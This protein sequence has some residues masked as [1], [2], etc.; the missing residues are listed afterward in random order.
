MERTSHTA[1]ASTVH[2]PLGRPGGPGLFHHKGLQLPAYIQSVAQH[3]VAAHGESRAIEMAVGIVRDWAHGHDGRGNKVHPDVQAAAAK[4]MA[5]WEADKASSGKARRSAV[6]VTRAQMTTQDI[7]D[8]PD[9]DFAFIESGGSKDS[10][11][12]TV[13]RSLRHLPLHDAAHI[14]DALSRLPQS[15]LSPEQKAQAMKKIRA[16]AQKA[17][18]EVGDDSGSGM[19][20]SGDWR[21]MDPRPFMVDDLHIMRAAEGESSGRVVEGYAA[22]FNQPQEIT[23]RQGKYKE[24]IDPHAFDA[25]LARMSQRRGGIGAAVRVLF[26]HGKSIE[27]HPAPEFQKPIGRAQAIIPD[28]RGLLTRTEFNRTPLAEEVLELIRSGSIT[29]MSFQ[30]SD[31]RSDPPLRGPGDMYRQRGGALT[32]VRRMILGLFEYSPVVFEA[33]PGAE[34]LGVVRMGALETYDVTATDGGYIPD[35]E[36]APTGDG[37][38]AGY[39]PE[40]GF[41]SRSHAHRLW[42]MRT[43][44]LC[45]Q[46]GIVFEEK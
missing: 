22:V 39:L 12:K 28:S 5:Q 7:N 6:T 16:R 15:D 46:A 45:R 25:A 13:P 27:G 26:N 10:S 33:Y 24:I 34:F 9:S 40:D 31:I 44:E 18:V 20:R 38:S 29:G 4:A 36:L 42:Q 30:G 43:G 23:D 35:E 32:T 41:P 2:K 14:S 11:G 17:G 8:L 19:S 3:L 1:E 37:G 21:Q